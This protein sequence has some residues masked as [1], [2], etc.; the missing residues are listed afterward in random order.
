MNAQFIAWAPEPDVYGEA[1]AMW[2]PTR[3]L[4][5]TVT[6]TGSATVWDV[7]DGIDR[8][9]SGDAIGTEEAKRAAEAAARRALFAIV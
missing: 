7:I 1:A 2:T 8:I 3:L 4:D 6:P 9:A 5:L